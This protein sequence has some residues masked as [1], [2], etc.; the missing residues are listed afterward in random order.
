[1]QSISL[2]YN[3]LLTS[4]TTHDVVR[5]SRCCTKIK[6]LYEDQDVVLT[7]T[8]KSAKIAVWRNVFLTIRHCTHI[9]CRFNKNSPRSDSP[10][11]KCD[12]SELWQT[13]RK[14][15]RTCFLIY[16]FR[17]TVIDEKK[18]NVE[19]KNSF[20]YKNV[21]YYPGISLL[22]MLQTPLRQKK[23]TGDSLCLTTALY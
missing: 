16:V 10:G 2:N 22:H 14:N 5:R 12:V 21:T 23:N 4:K 9:E 18:N 8:G 3:I 7:T 11:G 15:N 17:T 13:R 20:V 19:Q 1:M 6:M